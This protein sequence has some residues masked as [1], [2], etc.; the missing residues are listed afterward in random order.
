MNDQ[1]F[2]AL[3]GLAHQSC[4]TDKIIIFLA[5]YLPYILI[6]LTIIYAFRA[7]FGKFS[8]RHPFGIFKKRIG[9]LLDTLGLATISW[10]VANILKGIIN[11]PRP[12]I[13]FKESIIPLFSHGGMDSFPSGH[14]SFFSAL[15]LSMF[16]VNKKLGYIVAA[17]ALL[18]GITRIISGIHFPADIIFG[19]LIG[20]LVVLLYHLLTRTKKKQ[21]K[22]TIE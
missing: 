10:L 2:F 19:Y 11:S 9:F 21:I 3:H 17:C 14:A 13:V 8:L 4:P 16:L 7:D 12:F 22:E 15:A 18:I 6:L 1:I 5:D 20:L